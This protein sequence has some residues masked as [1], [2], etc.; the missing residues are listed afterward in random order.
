MVGGGGGGGVVGGGGISMG[1]LSPPKF[2]NMNKNKVNVCTYPLSQLA[3]TIIIEWS[4]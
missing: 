4:C 2:L 3:R 1:S